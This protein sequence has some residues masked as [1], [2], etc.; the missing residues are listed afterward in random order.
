VEGLG[1]DGSLLRMDLEEMGWVD[2]DR[3]AGSN[4]RSNDLQFRKMR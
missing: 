1:V 3:G 2:M 4:E